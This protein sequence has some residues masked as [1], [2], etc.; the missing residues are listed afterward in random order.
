MSRHLR[1]DRRRVAARRRREVGCVALLMAICLAD[2]AGPAL[3]QPGAP[4]RG[5]PVGRGESASRPALDRT[6]RLLQR[7]ERV[8]AETG[9][10][11]GRQYLDQAR[12]L[13]TRAGNAHEAG[14]YAEAFRL[15]QL[16]RRRAQAAM[17]AASPGAGPDS[18]SGA[19]RRTGVLLDRI[20]PAVRECRGA[21]AE[22]DFAE[23]RKEETRARRSM[24][25]G[26]PN[27]AVAHLA[28]ARERAFAALAAAEAGCGGEPGRARRTVERTGDLLGESAWLQRPGGASARHFR[29]AL[30]LHR[31]A[32]AALV[33][34]RYPEAARLSARAR[35][36]LVIALE[37]ADRPLAREAVGDAV[38]RSRERL[39][40]AEGATL[41]DA[42]PPLVEAR[43]RQ[44]RAE[45]LFDQGRLAAALAE[46]SAVT[47][48][49][50]RLGI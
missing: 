14:L 2:A 26:E 44:R 28:R 9:N 18:L 49:L 50:D 48:L 15:T 22:R 32:T 39:A 46:V 43:D 11:L 25:D 12:Q 34:G 4:G 5:G 45:A 47:G 42:R 30:D 13:Q 23:A 38:R 17:A 1:V 8:V 3:A 20:E 37:S 36:Q 40:A 27:A 24:L 29:R 41:G 10:E 31:D 16:A 6:E 21:A 33:S 19:L 7:A 35:V